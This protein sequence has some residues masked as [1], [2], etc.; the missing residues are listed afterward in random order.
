MVKNERRG[1]V[2]LKKI[3]NSLPVIPARR[4]LPYDVDD[5]RD[6]IL[7]EFLLYQD[8]GK[9]PNTPKTPTERLKL[10]RMRLLR[11]NRKRGCVRVAS[12]A[13]A[14]SI[15]RISTASTVP[16]FWLFGARLN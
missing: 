2:N 10:R 9:S 15:E 13:S 6:E 7:L 12:A 16:T 4:N 5:N 11:S 14:T 8:D 3:I 1:I